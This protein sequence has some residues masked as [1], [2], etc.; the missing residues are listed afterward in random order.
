MK[1]HS[2][3]F[4]LFLSALLLLSACADN[5]QN[6]DSQNAP[7][8]SDNEK[9]FRSP[10]GDMVVVR[11]IK[12]SDTIWAFNNALGEPL[13]PNCDSLQVSTTPDG[14]P[15]AVIFCHEGK[16]SF[17]SFWG[18]MEKYAEGEL[19]NGKSDGL[20]IAYDMNTGKKQSE[21]Y[22]TDGIENGSYVVYNEN[23]TPSIV[24]QNEN[25]KRTGKWSFYDKEGKLIDTKTFK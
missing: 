10:N 18:N 20:W 25:G 21:T 7:Q 6:A 24:G 5:S 16:Q 19:K 8:S 17:L 4:S 3:I 15:S 23:G 14:Q 9:V 22:F 1:T 12:G 11:T 2:S 13:M